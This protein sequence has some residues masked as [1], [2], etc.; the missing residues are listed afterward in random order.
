MKVKV[1]FLS[2]S[3]FSSAQ[4]LSPGHSLQEPFVDVLRGFRPLS[5]LNVRAISLN[6]VNL[7]Q[8]V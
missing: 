1:Y 8:T 4:V 3:V 6:G 2:L 7:H 5:I